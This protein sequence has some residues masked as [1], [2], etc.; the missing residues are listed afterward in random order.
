MRL[1]STAE[2]IIK[3]LLLIAVLALG[4]VLLIKL[5][6]IAVNRFTLPQLVPGAVSVLIVVPSNL[7]SE[8][9][10]FAGA[11]RQFGLRAMCSSVVPYNPSTDVVL[12]YRY[13]VLDNLEFQSLLKY[14]SSGGVVIFADGSGI[15]APGNSS[16]SSIKYTGLGAYL[17]AKQGLSPAIHFDYVLK[18]GPNGTVHPVKIYA[19]ERII[20]NEKYFAQCQQKIVVN[21]TIYDYTVLG[22]DVQEFNI[23]VTS[24]GNRPAILVQRYGRGYLVLIPYNIIKDICSLLVIIRYTCANKL[25]LARYGL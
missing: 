22:T 1:A 5:N 19:Y 8:C 6:I 25:F 3:F 9:E 12:L 11:L 14:A 16:N 17:A 2:Q 10:V 18:T 20:K 23:L 13:K 4:A 15:A 21:E 24:A 7:S